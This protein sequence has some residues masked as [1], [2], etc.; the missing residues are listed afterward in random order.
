MGYLRELEDRRQTIL[1][2]IEEQ[3]KLS[4]PLA[5]AINATLSKT[6]LEDL[7]LPYKLKRRTHGQIA[8]KAG[9]ELLAD[10]LWQQP[11]QQPEQLA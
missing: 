4:E 6:E 9:L 7:Y 11:Q 2:S 10:S 3:S 8:I 5:Q 1:K